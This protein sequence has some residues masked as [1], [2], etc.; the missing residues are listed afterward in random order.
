MVKKKVNSYPCDLT[1]SFQHLMLSLIGLL[2]D[3]CFEILSSSTS[4]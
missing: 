1:F 2:F 3:I 4:I